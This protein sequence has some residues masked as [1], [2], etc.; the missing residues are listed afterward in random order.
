MCFLLPATENVYDEEVTTDLAQSASAIEEF[1]DPSIASLS[2][3]AGWYIPHLHHHCCLQQN[4]R[5]HYHS[6]CH[7]YL[8]LYFLF[9]IFLSPSFSSLS[10]LPALTTFSHCC[11]CAPKIYSLAFPPHTLLVLKEDPK[12]PVTASVLL[13]EWLA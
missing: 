10:P 11:Q 7:C 8:D 9:F 2:P 6:F 1:H 3:S 4:C 13:R 12:Q 5:Q